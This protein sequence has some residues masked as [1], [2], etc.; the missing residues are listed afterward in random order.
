[1]WMLGSDVRYQWTARD[2]TGSYQRS[3]KAVDFVN[4]ML[5]PKV[6]YNNSS[7]GQ[8]TIYLAEKVTNFESLFITFG[9]SDGL[10]GGCWTYTNCANT[11]V[12]LGS[13]M[14]F[15]FPTGRIYRYR[16]TLT[17][18]VAYQTINDAVYFGLNWMDYINEN[19]LYIYRIVGMRKANSY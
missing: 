8:G 17:D 1:M 14:C 4:F 15:S 5:E 2:S 9:Y 6:L 11:F 13:T 10:V 18:A 3:I 16:I 19:K 12:D 7:G